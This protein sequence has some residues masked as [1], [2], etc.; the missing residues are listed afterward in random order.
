MYAEHADE[1]WVATEKLE[2]QN[3]SI[4]IQKTSRDGLERLQNV[5]VSVLVL[6]NLTLMELALTSG[7]L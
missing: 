7:R 6:V 1:E 4:S 5:S 3:I 2:G